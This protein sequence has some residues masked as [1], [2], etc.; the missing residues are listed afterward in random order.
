VGRAERK[1][2]ANLTQIRPGSRGV[3]EATWPPIEG[4]LKSIHDERIVGLETQAFCIGVGVDQRQVS[5]PA[6]SKAMAILGSSSGAP[7]PNKNLGE[8]CVSIDDL[9]LD[10]YQSS[11]G[12]HSSGPRV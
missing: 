4:P 11:P 12:V 9:A 7:R 3:Y 6:Y 10:R 1:I 8:G 2:K 5:R